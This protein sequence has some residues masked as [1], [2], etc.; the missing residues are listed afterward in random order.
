MLCP[1]R[2]SNVPAFISKDDHNLEWTELPDIM[3][4]F[5]PFVYPFQSS[6][7]AHWSDR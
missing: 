3:K 1:L 5:R 2:G 7:G 6:M 4:Q